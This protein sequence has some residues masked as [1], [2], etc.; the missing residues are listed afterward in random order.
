MLS[1]KVKERGVVA[2]GRVL[3]PFTEDEDFTASDFS[4]L[5]QFTEATYLK[6]LRES[7]DKNDD[8]DDGNHFW[9]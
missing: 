3:G 9:N 1:F 2:N 8:D 7:L 6:K 5:E 4:L